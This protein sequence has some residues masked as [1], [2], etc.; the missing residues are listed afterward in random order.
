MF[1]IFDGYWY[2]CQ[3]NRVAPSKNIKLIIMIT[4]YC[5]LFESFTLERVSFHQLLTT[6]YSDNGVS[7]SKIE[8]HQVRDLKLIVIITYYC[9]LFQ[10]CLQGECYSTN[11]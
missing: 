3:Y 5:D 10:I 6:Y 11:S 4:F 9:D 8:F 7:V 1:D 2:S